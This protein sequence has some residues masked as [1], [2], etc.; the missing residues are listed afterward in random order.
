[1]S[2]FIILHHVEIYVIYY[3]MIMDM[4]M[5]YMDGK[6]VLILIIEKSLA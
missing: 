1:M 2:S 5:V 3:H 6:N 4:L